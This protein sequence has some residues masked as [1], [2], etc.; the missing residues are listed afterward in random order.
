[1]CTSL[2]FF[3]FF[4]RKKKVIKVSSV[5]Q[6]CD[7]SHYTYDDTTLTKSCR[8]TP[9]YAN[10]MTATNDEGTSCTTSGSK[11]NIGQ[12]S[13]TS[14]NVASTFDQNSQKT[15]ISADVHNSVD[16]S[17]Q[18]DTGQHK[19]VKQMSTSSI[20][21]SEGKSSIASYTIRITSVHDN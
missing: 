1:M 11:S 5:A 9:T 15:T 4:C 19:I 17:S 13:P 21:V 20:Q 7:L 12:A 2:R 6:L 8:N 18:D 10:T 16:Q 3:F 14:T